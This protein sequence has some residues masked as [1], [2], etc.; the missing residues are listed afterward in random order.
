LSKTIPRTNKN[1]YGTYTGVSF[2]KIQYIVG[3][4]FVILK[5]TTTQ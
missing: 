1:M 5:K 4:A 3:T 2:G